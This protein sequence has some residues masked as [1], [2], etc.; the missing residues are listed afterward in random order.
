MGE[1]ETRDQILKVPLVRA[2]PARNQTDNWRAS[3]TRNLNHQAQ[4]DT[5]NEGKKNTTWAPRKPFQSEHSTARSQSHSRRPENFEAKSRNHRS[6]GPYKEQFN[7]TL[8]RLTKAESY[9]VVKI[10][11]EK[12]DQ[13]SKFVKGDLTLQEFQLLIGVLVKVCE[14]NFDK[15]KVMLINQACHPDFMNT[16]PTMLMSAST[17]EKE[18]FIQMANDVVNFFSTLIMMLPITAASLKPAMLCCHSMIVQINQEKPDTVSTELLQQYETV[19]RDVAA[20]QMQTGS[21]KPSWFS[22]RKEQ[23]EKMKFEQ[24]PND[25]REISI[26]PTFEDVV[27]VKP[28]FLRPNIINGPYF[29]VEH[30]LD[31]QFR[32]LREDFV[33]PLRQGVQDILHGTDSRKKE[34]LSVRIYSRV[35]FL[36]YVRETDGPRVLNEGTLLNFDTSNS[37]RYKNTNWES[38]KKFMH[39]ALLCFTKNSFETLLF[40]TVSSR[41]LKYL[42][43][44]Q[45]LVKFQEKPKEDI[46]DPK[47]WYTMIESEVFFEPYYQVL[48]ALKCMYDYNFPFAKYIVDVQKE[49]HPPSYLLTSHNRLLEAQ[50]QE[51]RGV[52]FSIQGPQGNYS[53]LVLDESTWPTAR[54]LGLDNS[55]YQALKAALTKELAVIQGP[56]GTGKTFMALK[57]AEILIR[58]KEAMCRNT[59]ILVVCLTNHALDQFLVGMLPFTDDLVRIGGQSKREELDNFNMKKLRFARS[60]NFFQLQ[61]SLAALFNDLK[62]IEN[63]MLCLDAAVFGKTGVC[64][65]ISGNVIPEILDSEIVMLIDL[66]AAASVINEKL[67]FISFDQIVACIKEWKNDTCKGIDEGENMSLEEKSYLKQQVLG[68]SSYYLNEVDVL[69]ASLLNVDNTRVSQQKGELLL[70]MWEQDKLSDFVSALELYLHILYKMLA[71]FGET[72]TFLL[73]SIMEKQ[74][75]AEELKNMECVN[76]LRS[77]E[78]IGMTTN[79]AAR[80]HTLLNALGCD[81]VIVEEAAEVME[82]HIIAS[83][84]KKCKH[85]ILIGDHKQ[86][87][88]KISEYEL[89]KFYNFDISLFE[90]MVINREGCITL[91]VQHR[92][93]PEM[94]KLIVPTIYKTLENH[95]SVLNR[96]NLKSLTQRL[97]FVSHTEPEDQDKENSSRTN[98]FEAKYLIALCQHLLMQGYK[99]DQ[100]TLLT[101]YKGQMFLLKSMIRQNPG[102]EGLRS[103]RVVVVDD[104]QGEESDIILLSLVRSNPEGR[105]GFLAIENRVCVALS[106]AKQGFVMIGDMDQLSANNSIWRAVRQTIEE[107]NGLYSAL[108]LRCEV[109]PSYKFQVAKAE[110]FQKLA[111]HGGCNQICGEQL[112]CGHTCKSVCHLLQISHDSIK[113]YEPCE[114]LCDRGLHKCSLKCY[115]KRCGS[116]CMIRVTKKL[117]CGHEATMRCSQN[118]QTFY[119]TELVTKKFENCQ[120]QAE[121][122]CSCKVC[123]KPCEFQVPCGHSC[124][125]NCHTDSDPDHLEYKCSKLCSN[126]NKGCRMDHSCQK[127]CFEECDVCKIKVK[128]KRSCGHTYELEC[129]IDPE[130]EVCIKKCLK[131]LD[132]GHKCRRKC[133]DSCTPCIEPVDKEIEC[134]HTAKVACGISAARSDCT[135]QCEKLLPCGHKCKAKC[136][137]ECTVNCR[138]VVEMSVGKCGHEIKRFCFEKTQGTIVDMMRCTVKCGKTLICGHECGGSCKGCHQGRFHE[139]CKK[140]CKRELV[141][142]HRCSSNCGAPC[143]T[144]NGSSTEACEHKKFDL[145]CATKRVM[146]LKNSTFKC[147]HMKKDAVCGKFLDHTQLCEE[148]CS[149]TLPCNHQCAGFCGAP[150]P[151][152]CW[153]CDRD[154]LRDAFEL[155]VPVPKDPRFILLPDCHHTVEATSLLSWFKLQSTKVE[156]K[157]CPRCRVPISARLQN[158]KKFIWEAY[159][160]FDK[161]KD[162][163]KPNNKQFASVLWSSINSML[164]ECKKADIAALTNYLIFLKKRFDSEIN[165][166]PQTGAKK[167]KGGKGKAVR[168]PSFQFLSELPTLEKKLSF[169]KALLTIVT[170]C[171]KGI[172]MTL[173]HEVEFFAERLQTCG[174]MWMQQCADFENL[175]M[176]LSSSLLPLKVHEEE[177]KSLLKARWCKC[178]EC[179]KLQFSSGVN[180]DLCPSCTKPMIKDNLRFKEHD[181]VKQYNKK[182]QLIVK[183]EATN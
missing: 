6:Q 152:L 144:C 95:E 156:L 36:S 47:A 63:S 71:D 9:E 34:S 154:E 130:T 82:S 14:S 37:N 179:G 128:S 79:G 104:F 114:R 89:G 54:Q 72:R 158:F 60:R 121:V 132:C 124:V 149:K 92:M 22:R 169:T 39:G 5:R 66:D 99:A 48:G 40:A 38:S 27:C 123:P 97:S 112:N 50:V 33:R 96:P 65:P 170:A 77:K 98:P 157:V 178:L 168:G 29:D 42:K 177:L 1:E 46:L 125:R 3:A 163:I 143:I 31:T 116:N 26:Y 74:Q 111:P 162:K 146:C 76:A 141:C 87:R 49:D 150:C 113:C 32:L 161:I 35:K 52:R 117:P 44:R 57:I 171:D 120:H 81:I 13:F 93:A 69:R 131:E 28:P 58:N 134:G 140:P 147:D 100:I 167:S 183:V 4:A 23:V 148:R 80:L 139:P 53:L 41:D 55:Q 24:P 175:L 2:R 126:T 68:D 64:I 15:H 136:A 17:K 85:L 155:N 159:E 160:D 73:C 12:K 91:Q 115:V 110:D 90:R 135:Q 67:L 176:K 165:R 164:V 70:E 173:Q 30:Y 78:V 11:A 94:A 153:Q 106:R 145:K 137:D 138:E 10:L 20:L 181:P 56:P 25:F 43:N 83:V 75:T 19:S 16:F 174:T 118:E 7:F 51:D 127:K 105:I 108:P 45:I 129:H 182:G 102:N 103:V 166:E 88:P 122:A 21:V 151:G 61:D 109:H 142:G 8:K 84:S 101:T 119:C 86:L 18:T 107:Q 62:K 172:V 133:N 180:Y 59:P